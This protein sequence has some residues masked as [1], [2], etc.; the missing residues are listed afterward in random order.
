MQKT[1]QTKVEPATESLMDNQAKLHALIAYAGLALGL[2]IGLPWFAGG[3]WA[4]IKREEAKDTVY[5]SHY[6]NAIKTFWWGLGISL[7]GVLLTFIF[8]GYLFIAGAWLWSV[9]RVLKGF[10]KI[11]TEKPY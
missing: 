3:I 6:S 2:F 7:L 5:L 10:A 4:I 11:T 8:V 9:Y 1:D